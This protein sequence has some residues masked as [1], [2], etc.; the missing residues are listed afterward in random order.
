MMCDCRVGKD[1]DWPNA[2]EDHC[3]YRQLKLK[4]FWEQENKRNLPEGPK[5]KRDSVNYRYD[6]LV[7]TFLAAM[8]E[9]GSHGG[10]KYGDD[11]Y[12]KEHMKDGR[13][14]INHMYAH[15]TH[16]RNHKKYDHTEI[17]TDRKYH[18]AAIAFNAMMEFWYEENMSNVST[19]Q[20]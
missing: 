14:P 1:G 8:A 20:S 13:S 12:Q 3:R 7:P 19:D 18:L 2:H 11:N 15:L 16:Y 6:L 5:A 17:G 9:I 10:K 4:E